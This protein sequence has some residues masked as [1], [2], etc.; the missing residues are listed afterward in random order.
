MAFQRRDL[1]RMMGDPWWEA[2][3][4]TCPKCD[5]DLTGTGGNRC[6]ECGITYVRS[7]ITE[8][9]RRMRDEL[10]RMGNM[11]Q[12]VKTGLKFALVGGAVLGLGMLRAKATPSLNEVARLIAVVCG[13]PAVA[14]GLNVF[15]IKRLPHWVVEYL[16]QRPSFGLG[17][18]T[19]A[20]GVVLI[21]L[22]VL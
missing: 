2:L 1:D 9:A 12:L 10:R 16:P 11:N 14:L 8:R 21:T 13:V 5:Y 6:P 17:M 20:L 3:P 15:R 18:L 19:A 22:S 4:P 7:V